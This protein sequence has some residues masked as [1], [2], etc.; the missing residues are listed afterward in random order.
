MGTETPRKR[1][2]SYCLNWCALDAL[3]DHDTI[4]YPDDPPGEPPPPQP[5]AREIRRAVRDCAEVE[6]PLWIYR[7]G[8]TTKAS[9]TVP[10]RPPSEGL[11][12]DDGI[13]INDFTDVNLDKCADWNL[14]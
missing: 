5:S 9:L 2:R 10:P 4:I 8:R 6:C 13:A 11:I 7:M 12:G 3:A 1:I 14:E